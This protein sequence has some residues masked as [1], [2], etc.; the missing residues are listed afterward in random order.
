MK[1]GQM[2]K[3]Q[4]D[5]VESLEIIFPS[6]VTHLGI[7]AYPGYTFKINNSAWA[8]SVG[9]TGIYELDLQGIGKIQ[10]LTLGIFNPP[11]AL[12]GNINQVI[13]DYVMEE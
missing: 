7:Q 12:E 9:R 2:I 6:S 1:I 8:I 4:E 10:S 5:L 13:I 11:G 3:E